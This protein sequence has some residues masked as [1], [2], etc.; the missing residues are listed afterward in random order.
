MF[1]YVNQNWSNQL[2]RAPAG[3]R[4]SGSNTGG[5]DENGRFAPGN[6]GKPRGAKH[7]T[8]R[9]VQ[10][11]LDDEAEDLTRRAVEL[12]LEGDTTAMRLC[13]ERIAP[14]VKDAPVQFELPKMTSA[15]DAA[16]GAQAVLQAVS[17]GELTPSQGA[18]VMALIETYRRTLETSNHERRLAALELEESK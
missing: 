17:E 13:L 7:R 8:T 5:R 14:A 18:S 2:H 4:K 15:Q 6:P 10:E 16:E 11:L 9:A 12:A 3:G 1:I